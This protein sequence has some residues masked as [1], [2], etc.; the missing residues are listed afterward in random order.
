MIHVLVYSLVCVKEI[1]KVDQGAR[2]D[3]SGNPKCRTPINHEEFDNLAEEVGQHLCLN[4][5]LPPVSSFFASK[6]RCV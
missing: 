1:E 2:T 3:F 6:P 4:G 5:L